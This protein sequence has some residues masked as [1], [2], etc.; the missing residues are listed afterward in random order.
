MSQWDLH[1][2]QPRAIHS[3]LM[4]LEEVAAAGPGVTVRELVGR[5]NMP[6]AT[7]YRLVNL[8]VEDE[9]LVRLADIS[10]LALGRRVERLVRAPARSHG[11]PASAFVLT[12]PPR[13]SRDLL[14]RLRGG[15]LI[16]VHLLR[17]QDGVPVPFDLD[18]LQPLS[19]PAAMSTDL[20]RSAAG[21]L[22]LSAEAR[23]PSSM[24]MQSDLL[25]PGRACIAVP[26]RDESGALFAALCAAGPSDRMDL[27]LATAQ[28]NAAAADEVAATLA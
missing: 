27:V 25:V 23:E 17:Y 6:R 12:R 5:L 20:D 3:A 7:V 9:Y 13:A 14:A 8:L 19:D 11:T 28:R 1:P 26:L 18:P 16:A 24:A 21:R 10:G 2:K 15:D 4:L 22:L